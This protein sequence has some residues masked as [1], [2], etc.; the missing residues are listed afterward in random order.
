[1]SN[2]DVALQSAGG[3]LAAPVSESVA[4]IS[5]IERAARDPEV[6]IDK[7]ERLMQMHERILSKQSE[8]AFAQALS[9]MQD[10]LPC[11]EE[12]GIIKN[13]AGGK[14]STY[15]KWEDINE[16]LKPVLTRFGFAL[17][18]RTATGNGGITVT[19]ILS[20]RGGHRETTDLT[21]PADNSG[22]KNT[23]Q[24]IA[25][26]VSYGKR[27]TAGALLNLTSHGEDD[28]G[29]AAGGTGQQV[30]VITKVQCDRI[31][32]VVNRCSPGVQGKFSADWPEPNTIPVSQY[33]AILNSLESAAIK[34]QAA[35]S[36]QHA[37]SQQQMEVQQ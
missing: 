12:R 27:Y 7:M 33:D 26:S 20:H 11:I 35:L 29:Q 32:A 15:A 18:F 6:N 16:A 30:R 23:V 25:S 37:E 28:D 17:S 9:E 36:R 8:V 34:H 14:Q 1:M 22:S 5:V 2:T 21:L 24:A 3:A 10:Q 4:L 31:L 13:K 19:G